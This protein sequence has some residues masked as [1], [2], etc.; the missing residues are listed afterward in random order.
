MS[1][2]P[3][4]TDSNDPTETRHSFCR[5]CESLCGL[6]IELDRSGTIRSIRP[7]PQHVETAGFAC[8]KG[9]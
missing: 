2:T 3:R 5:I 8:V 6:E 4:A 1:S 7:D 9:L